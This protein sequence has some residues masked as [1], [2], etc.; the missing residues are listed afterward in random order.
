MIVEIE[1]I[2]VSQQLDKSI[3]GEYNAMPDNIKI[4]KIYSSTVNIRKTLEIEGFKQG[5][6]NESDS[7]AKPFSVARRDVFDRE[8]I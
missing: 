8:P 7:S 6:L 2:F 3:S 4:E 1:N 5:S